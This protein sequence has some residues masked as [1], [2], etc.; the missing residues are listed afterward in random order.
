M[1]DDAHE[2]ETESGIPVARVYD[3]ASVAGLNLAE[4]LGEPGGFPFTR[5]VHPTMYRERAWTMRQYAGFATAEETNE[6]FR[7][8]LAH[9][10]P[11][12]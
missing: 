4:R 3:A 7:Y 1:T 9:G 5:G 6:R 8:L 2:R 10:A 12:L 11:G